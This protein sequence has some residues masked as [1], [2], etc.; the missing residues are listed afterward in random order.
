MHKYL[1]LFF[2]VSGYKPVFSKINSESDLVLRNNARVK[3]V[4]DAFLLQVHLVNSNA[5]NYCFDN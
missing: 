1:C 3:R 5:T 2:K 4:K